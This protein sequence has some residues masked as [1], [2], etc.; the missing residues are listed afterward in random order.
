MGMKELQ[1]FFEAHPA[2]ALGFSGGVDSTFL[3]YAGLSFGARV[4]P[5]FV[6][7]AF[8]P[9][10]E[11]ADAERA[12]DGLQVPLQVITRDILCVPNVAANP[13]ERC[14][15]CKRAILTALR[16]QAAADGYFTL[17]DGTNA[18]DDATDRPG[19]R[20]LAELGVLSPLRDCGLTKSEIRNLSKEAGLFTWDKPAY[21]C[22]ATRIPTGQT[23]TPSLLSRVEASEDAL[24]TLGFTDFRVRVTPDGAARLQ[25]PAAQMPD[26]LTRRLAVREALAPYFTAV[27][28]DLAERNE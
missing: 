23:I 3:L 1:S 6:K 28:L 10:F 24:F 26:I 19:T 17:V 2:V 13:A 5:Y 20:A 25:C 9:A 22:L 14:Y 4:Q 7:T 27:T 12:C 11:L 15:H 21:A 18:S 8:Q 16:D